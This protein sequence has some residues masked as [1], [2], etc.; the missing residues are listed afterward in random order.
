MKDLIAAM[1]AAAVSGEAVEVIYHG[2]SQPGTS[3]LVFPVG[4]S[5]GTLTARCIA[6]GGTKTFKLDKLELA[7][8][9]QPTTRYVPNQPRAEPVDLAAAI[10]PD[11]EML[12]LGGWVVELEHDRVGV[13]RRFKNGSLR[14]SP[15]VY[16]MLQKDM[17]YPGSRPWYVR[18]AHDGRSA[19][20][21]SLGSAAERFLRWCREAESALG[22]RGTAQ[23]GVGHD[24]N[25]P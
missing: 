4:I 16:M 1:E 9:Q 19:T 21:R 15:D 24:K 18:S 17:D 20:F 22:M 12:S 6:T 8:G 5:G 10:E 25:S 11:L 23:E 2:G 7:N 14:K 3:R 13:H